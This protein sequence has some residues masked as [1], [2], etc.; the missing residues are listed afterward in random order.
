MLFIHDRFMIGHM[1]FHISEMWFPWDL[2]HDVG[3]LDKEHWVVEK[4]WPGGVADSFLLARSRVFGC[5][6][7]DVVFREGWVAL[8]EGWPGHGVEVALEVPKTVESPF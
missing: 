3:E 4:E 7:F 1:H 2:S 8:H 5:C 6:A